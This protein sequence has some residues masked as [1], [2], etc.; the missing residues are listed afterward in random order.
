MRAILARV[1]LTLVA[2][3]PATIAGATPHTPA[4]PT[5]ATGQPVSVSLSWQFSPA[6]V[7]GCGVMYAAAQPGGGSGAPAESSLYTLDPSTG[8][9]TLVG[10]IGFNGVGAMTFGPDGNLYGACAGETPPGV[11]PRRADLIRID[12][13][14]GAGTFLSIIGSSAIP[15]SVFRVQEMTTSPAGEI[16]GVGYT[17]STSVL[18]RI[19]PV[20]GAVVIV[21]HVY[22]GSNGYFA[23]DFAPD[24]AL[25][26]I[27]A[28]ASVDGHRFATINTS[29]AAAT[30]GAQINALHAA[31]FVVAGEVCEGSGNFYF[32]VRRYNPNQWRL[33]RAQPATGV[34]TLDVT[35]PVGFDA[36]ASTRVITYDVY[37]DQNSPPTT[38]VCDDTPSLSCGVGPLQRCATY[39]WRVV[40]NVNGTPVEGPVWSFETGFFSGADSDGDGDVDFID[41]N[42]VLSDFGLGP[43]CPP[44]P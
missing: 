25:L 40:A 27:A 24:G 16:Y 23:L 21:G 31:D 44:A 33:M 41:L 29:T 28:D 36:L 15:N 17:E 22:M 14:T 35:A 10:P 7:S 1:L 42:N 37:I 43:A 20:T 5:G 32:A 19:N 13:A 9:F 12:P 30:L 8:A 11:N 34:V 18:F 39:F 4:P 6:S 2:A 26:A 38:L 3:A